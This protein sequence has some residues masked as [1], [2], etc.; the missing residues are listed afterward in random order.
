MAGAKITENN[1]TF[2]IGSYNGLS[3][4]IRDRDGC[5]NA[6]KLCRDESKDLNDFTKHDKFNSIVQYW[7]K[8]EAPEGDRQL[9][10]IKYK[11]DKGYNECKGTYIIKDLI[12]FIAEWVSIEYAFKVK[13]IMDAINDN[14][15]EKLNTEISKQNLKITSLKLKLIITM[16]VLILIIK[17]LKLLNC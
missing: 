5:V 17:K 2:T 1:E 6:G 13:H 14:N 15:M 16:L 10:A 7:M 3:V 11:L 8:N 12:H 4:L 9:S